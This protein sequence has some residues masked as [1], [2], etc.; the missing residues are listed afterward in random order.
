MDYLGEVCHD[1]V[2]FLQ[3]LGFL[4]K[5][6]SKEVKRFVRAGSGQQIPRRWASALAL[7]QYRLSEQF[8]YY[9]VKLKLYSN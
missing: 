7:T 4:Q 5:L 6:D 3:K 9:D 1:M 8:L 2:V